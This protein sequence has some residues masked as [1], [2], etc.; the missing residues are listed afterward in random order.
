MAMQDFVLA[1]RGSALARA[2]TR[3]VREALTGVA[4]REEIIRTTGDIQATDNLAGLGGAGV[5]TKELERALLEGRADAAVHSLKDLPVKLPSGLVLGAILPRGRPED[6]LVSRYAGGVNGLP[7]GARVGTGSP[8]RQAML[9]GARADLAVADIRGN[10][11]T[12]VEKVASG[13]YDAVVLAAAGLERLGW[14]ADGVILCGDQ[15]LS[16]RVLETFL[17][18]PGQGA[19]AVEIRSGDKRAEDLLAGAHDAETAAGVTAERAVLRALGAGCHIAL[20]TYG[21]VENGVLRLKV[22]FFESGETTPKTA[23]GEGDPGAADDL[24]R[25]VASRLHA[26]GSECSEPY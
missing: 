26:R 15:S 25:E 12:R 8:R 18:A 3:L 9:R 14:T 4:V 17:P 1:T 20:G 19:I 2:Q 13:E 5:F 24:G 11:P 23:Q 16:A 7:S 21:W 10:V 22:A 6:V